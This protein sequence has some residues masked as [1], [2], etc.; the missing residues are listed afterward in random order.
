MIYK[1]IGT[2]KPWSKNPRVKLS[3]KNL[4]VIGTGKIGARVV[5]LM[6]PFLRILTFDILRN[7]ISELKSMIKKADCITIHIHQNL[8]LIH[9]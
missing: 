4:L 7:N 2:V 5:R 8:S 6:D 3:K 9:I 1:N